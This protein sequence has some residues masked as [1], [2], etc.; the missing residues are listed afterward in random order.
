MFRKNTKLTQT[1]LFGFTNIVSAK[2]T[3]ELQEPEEEKFYELIFC[4]IKKGNFA[5]LYSKIAF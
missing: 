2:I 5:C 3:K 4:K 1:R